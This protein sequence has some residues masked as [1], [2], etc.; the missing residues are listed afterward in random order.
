M[1]DKSPTSIWHSKRLDLVEGR[2]AFVQII[3]KVSP[4]ATTNRLATVVKLNVVKIREPIDFVSLTIIKRSP[5]NNDS[6][7][8]DKK[9]KE[10]VIKSEN[11]T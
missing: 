2:H 3:F 10:G 5:T 8:H 9:Y 6:I 7:F 1:F 11:N 4:T